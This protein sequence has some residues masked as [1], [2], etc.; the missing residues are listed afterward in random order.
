[1]SENIL[2]V[3]GAGYIGSHMVQF[4]LKRNINVVVLD[5]RQGKLPFDHDQN[6]ICHEVCDIRNSVQ[7]RAV[8]KKHD[9]S[10]VIHFG[11][12]ISVSDSVVNP[13]LYYETNVIGTFNLLNACHEH[14]VDKVIFSSSAAVYG[15]PHFIPIDETHACNP[16]SP[17]GR[18]KFIVEMMLKDYLTAYGIKYISFRYFNAAGADSS[19]LLFENHEPETH[20]IPNIILSFT[21]SSPFTVFGT[22]FAT[23]D[24][25]CVRDYVHV[26]DLCSAHYAGI[27]YLNEHASAIFNLGS[28]KGYSIYEVIKS[29]EKMTRAS[30][31]ITYADRRPGDPAILVAN[32]E[33]AKHAL[34]WSPTHSKIDTILFDA[35]DYNML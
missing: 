9:V 11:Q 31:N 3:G 8:F 35:C 21:R 28:G 32:A 10:C 20:L 1:M 2:V 7:V 12:E 27:D 6:Q 14:G 13:Q 5:M 30:I 22:D 23:D 18:T 16:I 34:K 25:T 19:G 33:S 15:E 17:Y 26:T 24:G 4:L 29:F